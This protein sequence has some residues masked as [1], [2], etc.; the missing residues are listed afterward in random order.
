VNTPSHF[1][2]TLA[3]KKRRDQQGKPVHGKAFLLGSFLPDMPLFALT[4]GYMVYRR[5]FAPIDEFIFGSTYD[6]LYFTNPWWIAG[7]NMLHAP[8]IILAMGAAGWWGVRL[9]KPWGEKLLWFALGCGLHSFIDIFTH[10]DDG[11]LLL[12]PFNW[13]L[14]FNSPVSYWDP[15][16]YGRIFAPLEMLLNLAIIAWLLI[17]WWRGRQQHRQFPSTT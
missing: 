7:H 3:I 1:L 13:Q 12:F 2:I 5:W 15:N 10:F 14:R 4:I 8:L 9:A 16:H 17:L 6:A 11:P